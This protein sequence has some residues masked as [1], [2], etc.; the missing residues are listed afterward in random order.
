MESFKEGLKGPIDKIPQFHKVFLGE[1]EKRGRISELGLLFRYKLKAG[2]FFPLKQFYEDV[3]LG[4]KMFLKGRLKFGLPIMAGQKE[5]E[6]IFK[7]LHGSKG[8]Q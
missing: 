6:E 2:G 5:V 3:S 8:K 1:V 7:K 4:L